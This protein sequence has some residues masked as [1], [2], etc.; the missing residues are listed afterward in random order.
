LFHG[1]LDAVEGLDDRIGGDL[2]LLAVL[3][4]G[5]VPHLDRSLRAAVL[6]GPLAIQRLD[7][8]DLVEA[9]DGLL[10]AVDRAL[11]SQRGRGGE[12]Q[13]HEDAL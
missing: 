13:Q 3:A 7:G 6:E 12:K 2:L 1:S 10:P 5:R 8:G 9:A 11:R 4:V